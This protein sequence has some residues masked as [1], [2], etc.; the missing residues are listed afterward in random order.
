MNTNKSMMDN[1]IFK[2]AIVICFVIFNVVI[3]V[4]YAFTTLPLY[5]THQSS[6]KKTASHMVNNLKGNFDSLTSS[7][8]QLPSFNNNNESVD[9]FC[10]A[11]ELIRL[12]VEEEKCFSKE[13]GAM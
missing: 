9:R 7:G 4:S 13:S 8:I 6:P 10:M 1:S 12:L 2:T 11:R 3:S 5:N